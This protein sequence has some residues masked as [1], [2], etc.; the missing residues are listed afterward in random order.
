MAGGGNLVVA[1]ASLDRGGPAYLTAFIFDLRD[2]KIER[3]TAYRSESFE[4]PAWRTRWVETS[5]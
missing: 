5:K 3:E 4:V 1:E 2:G